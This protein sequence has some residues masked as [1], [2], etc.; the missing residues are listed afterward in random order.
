MKLRFS[1]EKI[2]QIA[3]RYTDPDDP[4]LA[5][6]QEAISLQGYLTKR[7]LQTV[8][9]W[10]SPRS[11][12][13]IEKNSGEYVEEITA[14]ALTS[15]VERVKIEVLTLL[16]GVSWPTASVILH[17][18]DKAFYPI[19]DFRALWSCSTEVPKRYEFDFWWQYVEFCR[20]IASRTGVD[21]R[22]LDRALWQ[23]SKEYQ[24]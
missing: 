19:L 5:E 13:H 18:Y 17:W 4:T 1:E 23:Y 20:E 15:S 16:D 7:Q 2:L 12:H 14:Y 10:K 8:A 3:Q 6:L 21:K 22:S 24:P 9:R 11:K